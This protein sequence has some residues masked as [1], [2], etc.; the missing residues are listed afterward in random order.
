V[1]AGLLFKATGD[2]LALG[3]RPPK[4]K[5]LGTKKEKNRALCVS[6]CTYRQCLYVCTGKASQLSS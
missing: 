5:K 3:T 4:K 2:E 6:V 1:A